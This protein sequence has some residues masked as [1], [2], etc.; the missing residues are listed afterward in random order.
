MSKESDPRR[1]RVDVAV[2]I[3]EWCDRLGDVQNLC[4]KV[5]SKTIDL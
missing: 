2:V 4:N 3:T 5:V 1:T